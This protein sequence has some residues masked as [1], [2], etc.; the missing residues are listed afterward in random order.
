MLGRAP[1][2]VAGDFNCA[3]S[4]TDRQRVGE[5]FKVDKTSVLLQSLDRD[6]RLIDCFKKMHQREEGFP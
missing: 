6:F 2:V 5:N 3:L 4:K 1:L